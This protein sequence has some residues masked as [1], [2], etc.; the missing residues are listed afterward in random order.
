MSILIS[1]DYKTFLLEIRDKIRSSQYQALKSVNKELIR[2]Y[3]EIGK[4][5]AEKQS[6]YNWG[7]NI[8]QNLSQ[9]LQKEFPGIQGFS[10]R[11]LWR[12]R[13][14]Y[15]KYS[16]NEKL[17]PL[18]AEIGWSHNLVILEK[19]KDDLERE[20]YIKMTKKYGWTKNV[21]IHQIEGQSYERFLMN[22][23][24]FDKTLEEKYKHQ[25]KLA[26]RDSYSFDF[27]EMSDD[28][29]EREIELGLLKNI[30]KF[31]L[32][33][34]HDFTFVGNQYK[35][36]VGGESFFIDLLLY[37]RK[38]QCL[39]AIELKNSDFKPSHAGQLQFYLTALDEKVKHENE[40]PSIGI[41]ICKDKNRTVVEYALKQANNPMGVAKY[42]VSKTLPQNM[43]E[44][45][46]SAEEIVQRL[47]EFI[48]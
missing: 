45:L 38:L 15:L 17:P 32:S 5:I 23:T 40:N 19:C 16:E 33:M 29:G 25:A 34:G 9:D 44:M 27:L 21:L 48:N 42:T 36:E 7:K 10:D 30:R 3:W 41:I 14:F 4:S 22:Q 24:N 18:V 28:Y 8:V 6:K 2:L 13:N 35:I 12:M 11:N 37:H 26:V 46:P 1:K 47:N 39:V 20:F 43:Q 31:L